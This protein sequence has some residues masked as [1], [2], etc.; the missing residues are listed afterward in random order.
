MGTAS[1]FR[2]GCKQGRSRLSFRC[3]RVF[4][5]GLALRAAGL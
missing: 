3:G 5:S 1:G 4:G 2:G